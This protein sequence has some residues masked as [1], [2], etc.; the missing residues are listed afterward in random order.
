MF[1][2]GV[3]WHYSAYATDEFGALASLVPLKEQ[4]DATG[5]YETLFQETPCCGF[6]DMLYQLAPSH[7]LH[8]SVQGKDGTALAG[9]NR[10]TEPFARMIRCLDASAGIA[11]VG[12]W[13]TRVLAMVHGDSDYLGGTLRA[14]YAAGVKQLADDYS[15]CARG[16]RQERR[17]LTVASQTAAHVVWS[18]TNPTIALA[19]TDAAAISGSLFRVGCPMYQFDYQT[20]NPHLVASSSRWLGAYLGMAYHHLCILG[21]T[22][23]PLTITSAVRDS[24]GITVTCHVP[25]PPLV[26]DTT[27]VTALADGNAGFQ[28]VDSG[29][30]PVAVTG[31][32]LPSATTVRLACSNGG[33]AGSVVRYGWAGT[34]EETEPGRTMGP[35]G[36]LRDS[37]GDALT[38]EVEDSDVRPMHNWLLISEVAT[39]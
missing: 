9:L 33:G 11:G 14:T 35:R 4:Q 30:S 26:I 15:Q 34:A 32:T 19:Q 13:E 23:T 17:P 5:I 37:A 21:E 16:G 1:A 31:V 24:T 27:W 12:K 10:G 6:A 25:T 29:G 22:W 20:D 39:T 7:V 36:N 3:R 8:M 18:K 2:G 38:F 28:V